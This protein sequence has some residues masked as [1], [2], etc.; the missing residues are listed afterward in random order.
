MQMW[1]EDSGG[2]AQLAEWIIGQ[3]PRSDSYHTCLLLRPSP[4]PVC[5]RARALISVGDPDTADRM[6][7][8]GGWKG[9]QRRLHVPET[10]CFT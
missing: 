4:E 9:R 3:K 10:W 7:H 5:V 1:P 2:R 6:T 8:E